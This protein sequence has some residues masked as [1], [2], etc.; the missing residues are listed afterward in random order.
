MIAH[1]AYVEWFRNSAPYINAHSNRTFV[2]Q[3]AGEVVRSNGF[4]GVIHDIALLASLGVRLVIVHGARPQIDDALAAR[5]ITAEYAGDLRVTDNAALSVVKETVGALRVDIESQLSMGLPNSPMA[6]ARLR[7]ASGNFVT[8][9]PLGVRGG[10]DFRYTGEV[11]RI[12]G[13]AIRA[14]LDAGAVVLLSPLGYSPTGEVFNVF[15]EDVATSA[16]IELHAAKLL[17]LGKSLTLED[18]SGHA[19]GEFSLAQANEALVRTRRLA[20]ADTASLHQLTNA[21][22][23]CRHGVSRVHLLDQNLD[24]ALLVELFTR[25]GV[26]TMINADAYD[27]IRRASVEDVG[28]ILELIGPL[29]ESG[30]LVRRSRERLETEIPHFHVVE[31]DNAVV[32]CAAVY[33][34]CEGSLM[35]LACLAVHDDYRNGGR[36]DSLLNAVENEARGTGAERL[37]VLTTQASHW[38][39]ERG[40]ED[41]ALED[42][43]VERQTFYNYQRGSKAL[44]KKL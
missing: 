3:F 4:A 11:R 2:V 40:F 17:F 24:G 21:V 16:A 28:G 6:G 42:L 23:A 19:A 38:F 29:E 18:A 34:Y 25:D 35:E 22:R 33:P 36:G 1:E 5:G 31:R 37:F 9:R 20:S 15:A 10:T 39:K 43:P 14:A 27:A 8:A 26:G 32:A 30:A 13:D 44:V 41:A 12:D 7:V